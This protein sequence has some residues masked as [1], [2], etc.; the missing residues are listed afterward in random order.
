MRERLSA[1]IITYNEEVNIR[2]ALDTV[3]W[4]DEIVVVDSFSTDRTVAICRKYT[5]KIFQYEFVGFGRLRNI[6]IDHTSYDW[7]LS[8]DADERVTDEL[9][10]EIIKELERG[11]SA[12]AYYIP[13]KSHFLGHWIRHCGWY[14][15]YRQ[16]QLFN[17][18][19]GRYR[20][21]LVHEGFELN[22]KVGYLKNHILQYPFRNL[23]QFLQKQDRYSTLMVEEMIKRGRQFWMYQ[24]ITHPIF[25][26]LKMFILRQGFRDGTIGLMLCGLYTYY[27][28]IKYAKL[29]EK[30]RKQ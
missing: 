4:T 29:W 24:L 17:K 28:F 22:G 2:E 25:T 6:A 27:T 16:P 7:I 9:R 12:D 15:D 19:K 10:R 14:P 11:P 23:N 20:E 21:D 30:T 5:D 26:F 1:Y 18:Q 3:K 8:V 13:R